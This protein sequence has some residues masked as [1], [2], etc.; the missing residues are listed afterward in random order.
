MLAGAADIRASQKDPIR[1]DP[2]WAFARRQT[3]LIFNLNLRWKN[4][5]SLFPLVVCAGRVAV[6]EY[7]DKSSLVPDRATGVTAV[8]VLFQLKPILV[9][10]FKQSLHL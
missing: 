6:L 3:D 2:I 4:A 7:E 1:S 9:V 10:D 5:P 8:S